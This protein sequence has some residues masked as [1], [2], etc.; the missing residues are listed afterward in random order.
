MEKEKQKSN[1]W[2]RLEQVIKWTGLSTNAF[3]I[4]IGLKRSENLYQIKR[5][6]FGISKEL[7][8]LIVEKYPMINRSWLLTG[9]GM[10][11]LEDEIPEGVKQ[12]VSSDNS[13]PFY[14]VDAIQFVTNLPTMVKPLYFINVPSFRDASFAVTCVGTAMQPEIP[15]GSTVILKEL[16]L[17]SLLPGEAYVVVTRDFTIV[18]YV[19]TISDNPSVLV[20][21]PANENDYDDI[22]VRK[23]TIEKLFLVKGIIIN[24]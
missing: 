16:S 8:R 15:N 1:N 4:N 6:S 12:S 17:D 5:G 23:E 3:A 19:R 13:I 18:R 11:F 24:R 22:I 10:I 14:N 9:D 20:L 7:A 2:Q 21:V